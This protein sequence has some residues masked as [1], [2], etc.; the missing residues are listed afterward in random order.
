VQFKV[1]GGWAALAEQSFHNW[2]QGGKYLDLSDI[3][4][5][6]DTLNGLN[7]KL[8]TNSLKNADTN[9][10]KRVSLSDFLVEVGPQPH[11]EKLDIFDSRFYPHKRNLVIEDADET[12]EGAGTVP[13]RKSDVET[14][15]IF[16]Q[17]SDTEKRVRT[18]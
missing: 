13:E 5:L 18:H 3:E 14:S 11:L 4:R 16:E 8:V 2:T 15:N 6:G 7:R 9:G 17:K 12:P 1:E 10:D